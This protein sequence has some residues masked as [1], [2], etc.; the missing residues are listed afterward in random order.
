[1]NSGTFL[2]N[3]VTCWKSITSGSCISGRIAEPNVFNEKSGRTSCA[4]RNS[5]NIYKISSWRL[6]IY[7]PMLRHIKNCT[8]EAAHRLLGKMN[9][10]QL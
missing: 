6:L 1:M 4:E 5:E 10:Q 2:A 8:K 9:G 3:G 7:E